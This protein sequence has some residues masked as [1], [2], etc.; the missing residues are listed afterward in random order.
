[1]TRTRAESVWAERRGCVHCLPESLGQV[2]II[3]ARHVSK[4]RV[5][6]VAYLDL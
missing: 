6:L 3:R 2:R 1:M 4:L 5:G